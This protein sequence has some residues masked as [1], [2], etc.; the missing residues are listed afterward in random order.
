MQLAES[1]YGIPDVCQVIQNPLSLF[2]K[3]FLFTAQSL[4][5]TWFAQCTRSQQQMVRLDDWRG[6]ERESDNIYLSGR[7]GRHLL[8]PTDMLIG[9]FD[10]INILEI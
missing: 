6:E 3:W 2:Q 9:L 1:G 4:A 7:F 10:R 5:F 8:S